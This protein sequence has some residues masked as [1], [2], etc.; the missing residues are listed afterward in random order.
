[1]RHLLVKDLQILRRS[2]L[3]LGLLVAYAA[4]IGLPVGYGLGA[5][6]GKPRVAF[7]NEVSPTDTTVL[8]GSDRLDVTQYADDLF[9]AIEPVRV[10]SRAEAEEAV[11]SGDALAALIVPADVTRKLQDAVALTGSGE[12]PTL[13]V[14]YAAENPLKR[15]YVEQ[16]ISAR[17]ADAN[18]ALSGRITE[19]AARYIDILLRG[20]D[21]DI[22]GRQIEA[23]GL[24]RSARILAGVERTLP[25]DDPRRAELARV[26][27]F[28][29]LAIENLD[30]SDEVLGAI[31]SPIKVRASTVAGSS[32]STLDSFAVAA[33][34]TIALMVVGVLLGAGMLALEREEHAFGRI[35]RGLVSRAALLAE[36]VLLGGICA[37]AVGVLLLVL[38]SLLTDVPYGRAPRWLAVL[39]VGALAF[40]ALGVAIGAVTRDVRAASLLAFLLSL[41]I[42]ALALVPSG[43]VSAGAYDAVQVV[44]AALPFKPALDGLDAALSGAGGILGPLA[45]LAALG[46]AYAVLAR[47]ALRRFDAR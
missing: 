39:A 13:E 28:A 5:P 19:V 22:L 25:A 36:K 4:V 2:P 44:S 16:T 14:L 6:P 47:L 17:V 8:V 1:V 9:E 37:W 30:L 23:L 3:L 11:R 15:R 18:R 45:H 32:A 26:R 38:L 41:P 42:A 40:A 24:Q 20:G 12:V 43:A 35:V 46:L 29:D 31:G 27:E 10:D 34:T 7:L 33:A 21:F